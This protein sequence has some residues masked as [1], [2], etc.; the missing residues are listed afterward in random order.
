MEAREKWEDEVR[1]F[2]STFTDINRGPLTSDHA[3][4]FRLV[5]YSLTEHEVEGETLDWVLQYLEKYN[6]P[7]SLAFAIARKT[8]DAI[9]SSNL[10]RYIQQPDDEEDIPVINAERFARVVFSK[11]H[12]I[13][14]KWNDNPPRLEYPGMSHVVSSYAIKNTRRKMEDKHIIIPNLD[15]L[16]STKKPCKPSYYA[17]FDGHGG[18]DASHYAAAHLHCHL[19]HH[20]G[21]QNDDVETALKEAFKKTDHMFVERAT[22]ERLRS[23]STAV[24]VVIMNDVLHLAWLG[25]SQALLMRNG[26]PVEIMQPHKPER[27]DERKRIEDLGGCVVWF[28]AWRVNGTL[29]VSRAIGDADHKPYVCGDADTT[30]VQLQGDEECVILA[31]DGLWDTMSPQKVCS[32]IQTYINTGSDLTTVACKL[33][34]MAKE[35]GSSDN[36]SVIVVFLHPHHEKSSD[37]K[38]KNVKVAADA[39]KDEEKENIKQCGG[40]KRTDRSTETQSSE[41]HELSKEQ[42]TLGVNNLHIGDSM[43]FISSPKLKTRHSEMSSHG[44]NTSSFSEEEISSP[45]DMSVKVTRKSKSKRTV[46]SKLAR[47]RSGSGSGP[48][49]TATSATKTTMN[50]TGFAKTNS[51]PSTLKVRKSPPKTGRTRSTSSSSSKESSSSGKRR[52]STS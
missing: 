17:V 6:A 49:F 27:E 15:Y 34:T 39:E 10:N 26:Q 12:E 20:K 45:R 13:C 44:R 33:V 4:P 38:Q 41:K 21:F 43:K 14:E 7:Q 48:L 50:S 40:D 28:G 2:L 3:L 29:S 22:R 42:I 36:I 9:L 37:N 16:F 47:R 35:G 5:T 19:V 18:V 11:V 52:Q 32:T 23:G 46:S 51:L 25:D 1:Q 24:N 30:S 8:A 31:C